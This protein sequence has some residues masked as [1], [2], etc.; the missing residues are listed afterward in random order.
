ML[1]MVSIE[2]LLFLINTP[3]LS[4]ATNYFVEDGFVLQSY[5]D[6]N[7]I[8]IKPLNTEKAEVVSLMLWNGAHKS[9]SYIFFEDE[10]YQTTLRNSIE[11]FGFQILENGDTKVLGTED[12]ILIATRR[13]HTDFL[14]F[15]I[16]LT[17]R[18]KDG[19]LIKE[20]IMMPP[21]TV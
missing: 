7:W 6:E 20:I 12:Y 21:P 15:S 9:V 8:W 3:S 18:N 19:E 16:K 17:T 11:E 14:S 10:T 1:S 5:N 13:E 4:E 2:K